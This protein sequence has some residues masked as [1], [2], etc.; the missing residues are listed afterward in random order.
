MKRYNF[1]K[2]IPQYRRDNVVLSLRRDGY[3]AYREDDILVTN[4]TV[5][6]V[7]LSCGTSTVLV[8]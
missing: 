3:V 4:A 1:R 2:A 6:G 5:L 8:L 7:A